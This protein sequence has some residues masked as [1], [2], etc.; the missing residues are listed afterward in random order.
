MK[1]FWRYAQHKNACYVG[2]IGNKSRAITFKVLVT[3]KYETSGAHI[4]ML[5]NIPVKLYDSGSYTFGDTQ[6]TRI[7]DGRTEWGHKKCAKVDDQCINLV[8]YN[9]F[10]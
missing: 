2:Y 5:V 8:T 7:S 6:H 9:K 1:Y 3:D 4:H 10:M